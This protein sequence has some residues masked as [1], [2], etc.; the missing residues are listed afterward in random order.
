MHI[1][2]VKINRAI[3]HFSFVVKTN[4]VCFWIK[5]KKRENQEHESFEK[6]L[7]YAIRGIKEFVINHKHFI[8]RGLPVIIVMLALIQVSACVGVCYCIYKMC[9]QQDEE[10]TSLIDGIGEQVEGT[11]VELP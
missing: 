8:Q 4:F 1:T 9:C 7:Y 3:F 5:K 6:S 10:S 11:V 2:V